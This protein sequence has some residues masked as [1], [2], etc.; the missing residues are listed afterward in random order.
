MRA[1]SAHLRAAVS[2]KALL[3]NGAWM[4]LASAKLPAP[5][6]QWRRFSVALTAAGQTDRA[7]FELRVEGAGRLWV[8]KVSA[9][10]ADNLKGWR[11]DVVAAIRELQPTLI[12]WGG[13]V[14]DPGEYRW[15]N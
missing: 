9:M 7:V 4:T 1:D 15:K 3:P 11:R 8:D 6:P 14:C 5:S 2:F 12:R 10:P 13:S